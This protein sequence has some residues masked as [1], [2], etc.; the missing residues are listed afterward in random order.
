MVTLK[1]GFYPKFGIYDTPAIPQSSYE[2]KMISTLPV[3][4]ELG[5]HAL[6]IY[7]SWRAQSLLGKH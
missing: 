2:G 3:F 4:D 1:V 6:N 7:I 5:R